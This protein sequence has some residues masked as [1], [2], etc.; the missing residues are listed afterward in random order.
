MIIHKIFHMHQPVTEARKRLRDFGTWKASEKEGDVQCTVMEQERIGRF[1][2]RTEQGNDI[3]ADIQEVA[4]EDPNNI[5]FRS[6]RGDLELAG[7]IELFE[8]RPNLTEVVLTVDYEPVS[9]LQKVFEGVDRFLNRQLARIEEWARS[10]DR[11][12]ALSRRFA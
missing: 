6:V 5:L 1:E 7:L 9:A 4:G 11:I 10:N 8:I 12:P 2:F 3:L